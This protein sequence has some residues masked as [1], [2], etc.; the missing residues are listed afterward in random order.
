MTHFSF[1]EKA[2]S[3]W[4]KESAGFKQMER[5]ANERVRV[6]VRGVNE[7]HAGSPRNEVDKE[8]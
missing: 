6:I 5:D 1:D 2:F 4:I 7:T 3:E 8:L